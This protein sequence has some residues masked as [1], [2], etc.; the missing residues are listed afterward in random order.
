MP[1]HVPGSLERLLSLLEPC[2]SQPVFQT[3]RA[4]RRG[5]ART[6]GQRW[7][8]CGPRRLECHELYRASNATSALASTICSSRR[9]SFVIES[10]WSTLRAEMSTSK[11][12]SS[13]ARISARFA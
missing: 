8:A 7:H 6:V 9:A 3:C 11:S 4:Q 12:T 13:A 5:I 10:Y 1:V 2:F